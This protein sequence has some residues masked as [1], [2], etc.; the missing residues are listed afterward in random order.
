MER[1][2]VYRAI[3]APTAFVGG[4]LS[5]L[6]AIFI[7]LS[8]APDSILIGRARANSFSSGSRADFD[9]DREYVFY[10][11]R[12]EEQRT[13]VYFFGNETGSARDRAHA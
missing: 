13:A 8:S 6:S 7:H 12:S 5:V 2:T 11:A 9:R 1:A 10:L 3:S 4:I